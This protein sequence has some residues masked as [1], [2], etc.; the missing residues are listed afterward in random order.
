MGCKELTYA[1]MDHLDEA[2]RD[3]V[4]RAEEEAAELK[5]ADENKMEEKNNKEKI[6]EVNASKPLEINIINSPVN[7]P[8][9]IKQ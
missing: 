2:K 1:M 5:K 8:I 6:D 7:E 4:K 3:E 9:I